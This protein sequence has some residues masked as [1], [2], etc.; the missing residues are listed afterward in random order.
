ME[1][2]AQI[3]MPK[4]RWMEGES[5]LEEIEEKITFMDLILKRK[6]FARHNQT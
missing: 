3:K 1:M 6:M 4:I 5:V 2:Y